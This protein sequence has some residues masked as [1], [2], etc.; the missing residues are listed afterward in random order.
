M[1]YTKRLDALISD[2]GFCSRRKVEEFLNQNQV[3]INGIRAQKS[4]QRVKMDSDELQVNNKKVELKQNQKDFVYYA[5][6]KPKGVLSAASDN[7]KR[8]T[9]TAFVPTK[10]R[11]YPVGRLDEQSTGLILLTNDGDLA[12]KLT[13][14]RYHIPKTYLIWTVG[15]PSEKRLDKIRDGMKL[16]D[17]WTKPTKVTILKSSP[18]R[19]L[20]E[21]VLNEGKNHQI[22]RMFSRVGINIVELKRISI[23]SLQLDHLGLG[24]YRSLN[25][26]ELNALKEQVAAQVE[27]YENETTK[28][29]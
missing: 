10:V 6:N 2:L 24:A 17:G 20:V 22:R 14:P 3:T 19:T 28:A 27:A 23:G 4:G 13:H 11:V 16:S 18:K 21:V 15:N 26:Q 9:V 25:E 5:V 8:K 7:A 12:H 29:V 1:D